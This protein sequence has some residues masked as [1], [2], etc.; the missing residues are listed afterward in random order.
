[1]QDPNVAI[2]DLADIIR[3]DVALS[4]KLLR[5]V[6][7]AY[8]SLPRAVDSIKDAIILLGTRHI[9]SWISLINLA[10]I[11]R[12]PKELTITA[13]VRARM[14]E[15][16]AEMSGRHDREAFY[17]VGLFSVLDALLDVEIRAALDALPLSDEVR[18][19]IVDGSG[20][21]GDTLSGV[22]AYER[23]DWNAAHCPG[24]TQ[25]QLAAIFREAVLASDEMWARISA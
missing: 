10:K 17:T 4:Y 13:L 15:L 1:M 2:E 22:I 7:S 14:C 12:K 9:S 23:A 19:A 20:V 24:V 3:R 16:A 21:M 11:S 25:G 8:Y 18:S 5:V 6:N